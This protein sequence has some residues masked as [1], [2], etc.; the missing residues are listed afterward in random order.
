[1]QLTLLS[2]RKL[3]LIARNTVHILRYKIIG[4]P[5]KFRKMPRTLFRPR[6]NHMHVIKTQIH[7]MR[8]SL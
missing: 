7:L 6:T 8:Q 4:A 3:T 2:Q 5:K 1:M